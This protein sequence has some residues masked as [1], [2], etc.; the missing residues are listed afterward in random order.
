VRRAAIELVALPVLGRA[1]S[2]LAVAPA[3]AEDGEAARVSL[4]GVAR[5]VGARARVIEKDARLV[6]GPRVVDAVEDEVG[7]RELL[8]VDRNVQ[9]VGAKAPH[10]RV[11]TPADALATA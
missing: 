3:V 8:A 1:V 7:A 2:L 11:S 4:L 10:R 9:W 5:G 6:G